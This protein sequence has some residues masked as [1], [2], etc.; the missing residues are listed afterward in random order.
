MN[1]DRDTFVERYG[2][3]FESSPWVAEEAWAEGPFETIAERAR[4]DGPGGRARAGGTP[5]RADP[6]AP[7]AGARDRAA[8][9]ELTPAS[10]SEQASAGLGQLE[11]EQGARLE[12]AT[13][14]YR[15]KFGFPFVVCVREHTPESII[16]EA[17]QRLDSTPRRGAAHRAARDR[18][19][20][21]RCGSRASPAKR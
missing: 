12:R 6:R 17:Q 4:G 2:P 7:R 20:R 21:R 16:A 15:D 8:L 1:L 10:A 14:A 19:D 3:A 18:Q 5:A 11:L 13:I 9:G